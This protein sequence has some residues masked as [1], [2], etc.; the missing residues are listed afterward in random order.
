MEENLREK[1]IEELQALV[2]EIDAKIQEYEEDIQYSKEALDDP[3]TPTN[4][5]PELRGDIN[6]DNQQIDLLESKKSDILVIIGSKKVKT[7]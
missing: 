1:T 4:E 7:L 6:Y 3:T 5:Y 2:S